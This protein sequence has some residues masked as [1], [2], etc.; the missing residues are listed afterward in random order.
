MGYRPIP[1]SPISDASGPG[2]RV[3]WHREDWYALNDEAFIEKYLAKDEA[4]AAWFRKRE[5]EREEAA[6]LYR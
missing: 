2:D 4:F 5:Q 1:A 6:Q 3:K